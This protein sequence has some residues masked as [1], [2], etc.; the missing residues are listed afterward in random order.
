ML[1]ALRV[2][3]EEQRARQ[4]EDARKAS[5]ADTTAA[6]PATIPEGTYIS[7]LLKEG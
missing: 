6:T 3:M 5:G 4:E 7:Y 1:Q 2:S